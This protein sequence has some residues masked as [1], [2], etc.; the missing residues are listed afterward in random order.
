MNLFTKH[1][2]SIGETYLEHFFFALL[3]GIKLISG[4]VACII[5]AVF[6][7][8]FKTTGSHIAK[9]IVANINQRQQNTKNNQ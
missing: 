7:F 6:P 1:P 3:A 8:L 4:G 2:N 5:H 9:Q